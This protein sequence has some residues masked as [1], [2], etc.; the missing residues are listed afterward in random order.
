[1]T[2]HTPDGPFM[3]DGYAKTFGAVFGHGPVVDAI[4]ASLPQP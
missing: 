2:R 4:T 3:L 1:M